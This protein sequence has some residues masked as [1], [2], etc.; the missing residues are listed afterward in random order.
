MPQKII[1]AT[2]NA[3]KVAELRAILGSDYDIKSSADI[4]LS[5]DIPEPFHTFHENAAHKAKWI[6]EKYGHDCIAED[7]G[8]S[9][10]SLNEAPGVMSARYSGGD[11]DD[12]IDK[13]LEELNGKKDRSAHYTACIAYMKSGQVQIFY[14]ICEGEIAEER[15]GLNG[16]GYDPIFIPKGYDE[17]F[18]QLSP[19]VKKEISH[20]RKALDALL[21]F[22]NVSK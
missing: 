1:F 9:I 2:T 3:N 5:D 10:N 4:G 14:G 18:G 20:R 15:L 6:F 19:T 21:A 13:V 7:S 17:T 8:L 22:L 11:S 12:N 16:F